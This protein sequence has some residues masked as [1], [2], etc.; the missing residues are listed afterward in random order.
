MKQPNDLTAVIAFMIR[1]RKENIDVSYNK[2]Y[3]MWL[4]KTSHEQDEIPEDEHGLR[5]IKFD[6]NGFITN[7]TFSGKTKSGF[8]LLEQ[9]FID[10]ELKRLN[11]IDVQSLDLDKQKYIAFLKEYFENREPDNKPKE[12]KTKRSYTTKHFVFTYLLDCK[13]LN[14]P[15]YEGVKND[16]LTGFASNWSKFKEEAK[17]KPS[18]FK[19]LI[20]EYEN[21]KLTEKNLNNLLGEDWQSIVLELS[22]DPQT[23]KAYLDTIA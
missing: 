8:D 16:Y 7:A 3:Q 19:R 12:K 21:E 6:E 11:S 17:T 5:P 9:D 13:A 15:L 14:R 4:Y 22:D 1:F 2:Q 10:K 23:L 18:T 20:Y